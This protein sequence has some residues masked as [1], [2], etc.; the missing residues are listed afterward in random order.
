MCW[1]GSWASWCRW[2]RSCNGLLVA[3][4]SFDVNAPDNGFEIGFF[5]ADV[6]HPIPFARLPNQGVRALP[7]AIEAKARDAAVRSA[8]LGAVERRRIHGLGQV[9]YERPVSAVLA[10]DALDVA[11]VND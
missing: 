5:D 10:L 1:N 8:E 7:V 9:Q 4:V 6:F 2:K 3:R 11:V